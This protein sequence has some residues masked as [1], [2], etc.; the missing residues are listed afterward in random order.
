MNEDFAEL[1][2]IARGERCSLP[3]LYVAIALGFLAALGAM[4]LTRN[5]LWGVL[6]GSAVYFCIVYAGSAKRGQ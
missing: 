6:G 3:Q 4:F 2:A 1:Q 5:A